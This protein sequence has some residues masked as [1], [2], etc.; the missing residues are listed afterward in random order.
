MHSLEYDEPLPR[1]PV[2]LL[3]AEE[4]DLEL[5][6]FVHLARQR[7]LEPEVV[8]GIDSDDRP[9]L[10]ALSQNEAALFVALRSE[11]LDQPRTLALKRLFARHAKQKQ[12][13]LALKLE[14]TRSQHAVRLVTRRLRA[15]LDSESSEYRTRKRRA[16]EPWDERTVVADHFPRPPVGVLPPDDALEADEPWGEHTVVADH[17]PRPPVDLVSPSEPPPLEASEDVSVPDRASD[18]TGFV[19]VAEAPEVGDDRPADRERSAATSRRTNIGLWLA[20]GLLLLAAW[21]AGLLVLP[22]WAPSTAPADP[23]PS[24]I[25]AGDP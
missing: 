24:P 5:V 3:C 21:K 14:P 25:T 4:D 22:S 16:A 17:L 19:V 12:K 23:P 1:V 15:V 18:D 2:V 9:L 10:E 11:N 13:L 6:S 20:V 8:T 7:G